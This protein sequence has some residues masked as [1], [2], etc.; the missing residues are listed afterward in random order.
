MIVC[1]GKRF[2]KGSRLVSQCHEYVHGF[3]SQKELAEHS[4]NVGLLLKRVGPAVDEHAKKSGSAGQVKG[5]RLDVSFPKVRSSGPWH[6]FFDN[7]RSQVM[8]AGILTGDFLLYP[9]YLRSSSRY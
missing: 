6:L 3:P 8:P 1:T 7:L 4:W 9:N 2:P 5:T